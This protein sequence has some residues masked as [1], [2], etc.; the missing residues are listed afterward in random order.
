MPKSRS[1]FPDPACR[2]PDEYGLLAAVLASPLDDLPKLV[3]ADFLEEHNDPRGPFL[4]QWVA[5][6]QA[7]KPRPKPPKEFSE[8][9]LSV[10]GYTIDDTLD[11]MG[12]PVW[13]DAVRQTAEP[14]LFVKTHRLR[15]SASNP[16]GASKIGGLPDLLPDTEWPEG[17]TG[18]AAFVAQWNLEELA[19]SPVCRL[20]PRTGLLSLFMDL[21]PFVEDSGDGI[22]KIVYTARLDE[23]EER[24]P[25]EEQNE[26]NVL[27][28]CR[29]EFH[30]WMTLPHHRSPVLEKFSLGNDALRE[31]MNFY[32]TYDLPSASHLIFGHPIPIQTDPAPIGETDWRL[33]SQFGAD[34]HGN[35]EACDGGTWYFMVR[36]E[37]L[38]R[39]HFDDVYMEFQTG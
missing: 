14:G 4:R 9:W 11:R 3:Y 38:K 17:E 25:D 37:D 35:L 19:L 27:S 21:V 24:E 34:G 20:L 39:A 33:L 6:K 36:D 13:A 2:L 23:L 16:T 22:M 7:G 31:Y 8:C 30:E 18:P 12:N 10:I 15:S 1:P 26:G 32:H 28:E 29:V 5:A